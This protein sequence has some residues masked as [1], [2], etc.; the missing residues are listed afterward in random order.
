[1]RAASLKISMGVHTRIVLVLAAVLL[2]VSPLWGQRVSISLHDDLSVQAVRVIPQYAG[3]VLITGER[4]FPLEFGAT[5]DARRE[6]EAV[7]L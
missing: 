7:S 3:Y 6:G 2:W 5:L 4:Q 1:M